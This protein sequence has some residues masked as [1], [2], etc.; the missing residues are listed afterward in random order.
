M[1]ENWRSQGRHLSQPSTSLRVRNRTSPASHLRVWKPRSRWWLD[2]VRSGYGRNGRPCG[3]LIDRILKG[4]K[5]EQLP[6]EQPTRFRFTINLKTA[7]ALDLTIPP[8]LLAR[9]DE[10]IE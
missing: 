9:A 4:A 1:P 8:T 3:R 7:K 5:P 10:V 6:F 2:V